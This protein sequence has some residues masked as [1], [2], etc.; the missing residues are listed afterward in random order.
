MHPSVIYVQAKWVVPVQASRISQ[1]SPE[2]VPKLKIHSLTYILL[3]L[4]FLSLPETLCDH[5]VF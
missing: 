2:L 3:L 5:I 4:F 1:G